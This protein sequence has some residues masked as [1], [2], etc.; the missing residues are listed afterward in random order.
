[1]LFYYIQLRA[2]GFKFRSGIMLK[3]PAYRY[4]KVISNCFGETS[5]SATAIC[6]DVSASQ[7]ARLINI[8]WARRQWLVTI[9]R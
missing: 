5:R 1:M 3:L 2:D 9:N 4:G 8:R 7:A 6:R